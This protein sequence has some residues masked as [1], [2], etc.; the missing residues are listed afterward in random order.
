[1]KKKVVIYLVRSSFNERYFDRFGI[2]IWINRGWR[3]KVYDITKFLNN[4]FWHYIN[5]DKATFDFKNLKI[6]ENI[7]EILREI[8]Q[9]DSPVVFI[10]LLNFSS[11]EMKIRK[12]AKTKGI[13]V[14]LKMHPLPQYI[15]KKNIYRVLSLL[16]RPNTF[17]KKLVNF[18]KEKVES[19]RAKSL[20][21]DF[22]VVG[23]RLSIPNNINKKKT[24]I[25][26]SHN[27]DYDTFISE[28]DKYLNNVENSMVFLDEYCPYHPDYFRENIK[29]Y[30]TANDYFSTI[31][32]GLEQI[33][34]TLKLEIKIAAHPSSDYKSKKFKYK[35]QIIENKTFKLIKESKIVVAHSSTSLQWAI[36]MKKPIIFVT[37]NEIENRKY[38]NSY[39]ESINLFAKTLGKEVI[40]LSNIHT[41]DN[42]DKYLLINNQRYEK[43]IENYVKISSSPNKLMW[44]NIID[45]IENSKKYFNNFNKSKKT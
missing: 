5:K 1:M 12:I 39:A 15:K 13:L 29:P 34:K 8:K 18:I 45:I 31:D 37:T 40:N 27:Y 11:S 6:F 41:Y 17:F 16:S 4:K 28:K 35:N 36:L 10:D 43:F 9:L 24:S 23:G 19:H 25:I 42:L 26:F 44:E 33:A 32:Y 38:E 20:H 21:P 2:N 7:D 3:V 14:K 22:L 30:V